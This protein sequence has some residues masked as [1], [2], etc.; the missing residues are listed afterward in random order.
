MAKPTP[1]QEA[2]ANLQHASWRTRL[3]AV[4]FL[5]GKHE[6]EANTALR[7]AHTREELPDVKRELARVLAKRTG[8]RDHW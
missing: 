7:Q 6:T 5:A 3:T 2:I 4:R 1:I 8:R